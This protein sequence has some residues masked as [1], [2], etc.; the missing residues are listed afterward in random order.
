V[1]STQKN[2]FGLQPEPGWNWVEFKKSKI[3][4]YAAFVN[5]KFNRVVKI[6]LWPFSYLA[7]LKIWGCSTC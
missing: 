2:Y 7:R 4:I 1:L 5:Q 3:P 6:G